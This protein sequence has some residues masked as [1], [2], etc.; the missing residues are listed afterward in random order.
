MSDATR[1]DWRLMSTIT[2]VVFGIT[3]KSGIVFAVASISRKVPARSRIESSWRS[4]SCTAY[5]AGKLTPQ[6]QTIWPLNRMTHQV[7]TGKNRPRC[8]EYRV[9]LVISISN[10]L[11]RFRH[12]ICVTCETLSIIALVKFKTCTIVDE[13]LGRLLM[14]LTSSSTLFRNSSIVSPDPEMRERAIFILAATMP[15]LSVRSKLVSR[16]PSSVW[17]YALAKL[18]IACRFQASL[19]L[20]PRTFLREPWEY[21]RTGIDR[22]Q[23]SQSMT[24]RTSWF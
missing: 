10:L 7:K 23:F 19:Q 24:A 9:H 14:G 11:M 4:V 17:M 8:M 18:G 12:E 16:K 13:L 5:S 6:C 20:F 3:G 21:C 2:L 1:S 22:V 15:S